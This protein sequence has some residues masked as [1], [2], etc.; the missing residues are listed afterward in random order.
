MDKPKKVDR[1]IART[2]RSLKS[3]LIELSVEKS[4]EQISIRDLTHR[5]DI[6]YATFFRHFRSKN[7]LATYCMRLRSKNC[8]TRF[9]R[10]RTI[11]D[12][13]LAVFAGLQ[14]H[15]DICLFGMSLPRDHPALAPLWQ[16]ILVWL[17]TVYVAR[18]EASIPFDVAANHLINSSLEMTRWWLTEGQDYSVERMAAMLSDLVIRVTESAALDHR[19]KSPRL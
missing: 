15:R 8:S 3:A 19:S 7:E 18:D 4:Y 1:R 14:K 5:A 17:T 13:C 10:R 12:E 9:R 11:Q 6:G 16:E 2:R